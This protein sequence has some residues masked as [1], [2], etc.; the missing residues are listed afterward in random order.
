MATTYITKSGDTWDQISF[1]HYGREQYADNLVKANL[2]H[3]KTIIFSSGVE[4]II[5]DLPEEPV[6]NDLPPWKRGG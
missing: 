6:A 5:P 1:T 2:S 3:V 4:L